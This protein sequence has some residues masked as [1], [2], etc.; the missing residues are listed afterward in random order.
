ML[1]IR[2]H[3]S[4]SYR[5]P[6]TSFSTR[7]N[8][9]NITTNSYRG[10]CGGLPVPS[11]SRCLYLIRAPMIDL[12]VHFP[13]THIAHQ[14][15]D[16]RGPHLTHCALCSTFAPKYALQPL[17]IPDQTR[18]PAAGR[19]PTTSWPA[20]TFSHHV[21]VSGEILSLLPAYRQTHS[22]TFRILRARSPQSTRPADENATSR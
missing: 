18:R 8:N 9:S 3:E 4:N 13:L 16:Q 12:L 11:A 7:S 14:P 1:G 15:P 19:P 17:A 21:I 10:S 5:S 20:S 2:S 22:P 6:G